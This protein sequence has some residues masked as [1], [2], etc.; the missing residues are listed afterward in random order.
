MKQILRFSGLLAVLLIAPLAQA[1]TKTRPTPATEPFIGKVPLE[2][3]ARRQSIGIE[4]EGGRFLTVL[5]KGEKSNPNPVLLRTWSREQRSS[6][7]AIYAGDSPAMRMEKP[8]ARLDLSGPGEGNAAVEVWFTRVGNELTVVATPV[9]VKEFP[10]KDLAARKLVARQLADLTANASARKP[11]DPRTVVLKP[12]ALPPIADPPNGAPTRAVG[13]REM[14]RLSDE[15]TSATLYGPDKPPKE[16]T[17]PTSRPGQRA[18]ER[19]VRGLDPVASI[20]PGVKQRPEVRSSSPPPG[21]PEYIGYR[22]PG[23]VVK[24]LF[25]NG[26]RVQTDTSWFI[27]PM[28]EDQT[29]ASVSLFIGKGPYIENNEPWQQYVIRDIPLG[30]ERRIKVTFNKGMDPNVDVPT[31]RVFLGD[32]REGKL[33]SIKRASDWKKPEEKDEP[34]KL[35]P[36]IRGSLP[37]TPGVRT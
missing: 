4:P 37:I 21:R 8:I 12:G 32:Q 24:K 6:T 28:Y 23:G 33:L 9:S 7:L 17:K 22:T 15:E 1:K 16:T 20:E 11:I 10:A 29:T 35:R 19:E 5:Q 36:V 26:K 2:G 27:R 34:R 18:P 14:K 25:A 31:A 30:V 13:A 3:S